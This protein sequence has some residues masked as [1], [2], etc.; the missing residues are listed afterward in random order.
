[1]CSSD[2][3]LSALHLLMV[4]ASIGNALT[5]G[6][7]Q[8]E[9]SRTQLRT[10][11]TQLDQA[12]AQL[13]RSQDISDLQSRLEAIPGVRL[14]PSRDLSLEQAQREVATALQNERRRVR[15]QIRVNTAQ[16]MAQFQRRAVQNVLLASL[17]AAVLAWMRVAAM[18]EMNLS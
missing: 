3:I 11:E 8:Q 5:L 12:Q 17:V 18:Q 15:S 13:P 14:K 4:P 9:I 16:S 2:L 7:K 1:M 10:I 6:Y